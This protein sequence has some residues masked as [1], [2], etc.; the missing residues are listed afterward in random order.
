MACDTGKGRGAP[1][2]EGR[3]L[4]VLGV[5]GDPAGGRPHEAALLTA[6]EAGRMLRVATKTLEKWRSQGKGPAWVRVGRRVAY[7][8]EAVLEFVHSQETRGQKEE[9]PMELEVTSRPYWKNRARQHVDIMFAHP[10]T[11]KPVRKRIVAPDGLDE[12]GAIA[13]GRGQAM[14]LFMETCKAPLDVEAWQ[15]RQED[16]TNKVTKTGRTTRGST[17]AAPRAPLL[18]E[19]WDV[20][21][22]RYVATLK[23]ASRL[24]FEES[25]RNHIREVLGHYRIDEIDNAVLERLRVALERKKLKVSSQKNIIRKATRCLVWA[26]RHQYVSREPPKVFFDRQRKER[27]PVYPREQWEAMVA[28]ASTPVDRVLAVLLAD[29]ALRIG[30]TAGLQ[31]QDIDLEKQVMR[32]SR[33]VCKGVVQDSPKGEVGDVPLTPRLAAALGEHRTVQNTGPWVLGRIVHGKP[34]FSSDALLKQRVTRLQELAGIPVWGPH[35]VR[36]SVLTFLAENGA[37]PYALQALARHADMAT[38][39]RYYIHLDR[40][41]LAREAISMLA[42]RATPNSAHRKSM[43]SAPGNAD[44]SIGNRR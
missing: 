32:I 39:M 17:P 8:R 41:R 20:F 7:R 37:T 12:A 43:P 14:R 42:E 11:Q 1:E 23:H 38:T 27:K 25:W 22:A 15:E 10:H 28:A 40:L 33:N 31:W 4:E 21:M 36:H 3:M 34:T 44:P 26:F 24:G 29:A 5:Q 16:T 19:F 6:D 2:G 30:E 13:W 9:S 18:S 35:R